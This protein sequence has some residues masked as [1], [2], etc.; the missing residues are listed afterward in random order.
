MLNTDT[1]KQKLDAAR[2]EQAELRRM[3]RVL[4]RVGELDRLP[5][6]YQDNRP[7]RFH[8]SQLIGI[9]GYAS[10]GEFDYQVQAEEIREAYSD[11]MD[12][13]HGDVEESGVFYEE[14]GEDEVEIINIQTEKAS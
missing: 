6:S 11:Y 14:T 7:D 10:V 13:Q 3:H 5:K 8:P 2:E 9:P 4:D 1:I 12:E